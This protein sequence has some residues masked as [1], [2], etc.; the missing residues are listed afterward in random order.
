LSK[1][2]DKKILRACK[3][4]SL[5][6]FENFFGQ[7]KQNTI[8]YCFFFFFVKKVFGKLFLKTFNSAEFCKD[9]FAHSLPSNPSHTKS[10]T[11]YV[12]PRYRFST[13]IPSCSLSMQFDGSHFFHILRGASS[14][15]SG[16]LYRASTRYF[17]SKLKTVFHMDIY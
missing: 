14:P 13:T 15:A 6:V 9:S 8:F 5:F 3:P 7:Q 16:S 17:F 1:V 12:P 2:F 4:V 11:F 10:T